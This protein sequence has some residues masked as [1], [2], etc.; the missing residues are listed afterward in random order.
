MGRAAGCAPDAARPGAHGSAFGARWHGDQRRGRC[1][2][3][4]SCRRHERRHRVHCHRARR[5]GAGR[6]APARLVAH[7]GC[8]CAARGHD[9]RRR[10]RRLPA[11][12]HAAA[13]RQS[14]RQRHGRRRALGWGRGALGG[15]RSGDARPCADPR[16][17]ERGAHRPDRPVPA[18][19]GAQRPGAAGCRPAADRRRHALAR[20]QPDCDLAAQPA[21]P[22]HRAGRTRPHHGA[23]GRGR[24][25]DQRRAGRRGSR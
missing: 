1:E 8:G 19:P 15:H 11:A 12:A 2:F 17:I 21:C 14:A 18:G 9:L 5:P 24:G 7:C 25:A 22:L 3:P 6:G 4:D 13:A 16:R 20:G 23:G 10:S